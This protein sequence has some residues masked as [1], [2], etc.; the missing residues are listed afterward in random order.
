MLTFHKMIQGCREGD[1]AAWRALATQYAPVL[2]GLGTAYASDSGYIENA[3]HRVLGQLSGHEF[4]ALKGI[5]VQSDREFFSLLRAS[6]LEQM[7]GG[8]EEDS[9]SAG[10]DL[11][12]ALEDL[13]N[14]MKELPLVHQ[15]VVFLKLTG[16]SE[17]AI[18]QILRISPSV[19]AT[20]VERLEATFCVDFCRSAGASEWQAAWLRMIG[21]IRPNRTADCPPVR[22]LIR[23]LDGQFGW[24]EKDPIEKHLAA[25]LC[26]LEASVGL[27]E[28]THWMQRGK[29]LPPDQVDGMISTLPLKMKS[30]ER[31]SLFK[32]AFR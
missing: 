10:F 19:A 29:P 12:A 26:C 11:S 15:N 30:K 6:L 2:M 23:I 1:W 21:R 14:L 9:Q 13:S 5:D 31:H 22:R 7:A 28:I 17:P 16:Y 32:R 4:A 18:E 8:L 20:S 25:C 24:Y 27:Q 3:W